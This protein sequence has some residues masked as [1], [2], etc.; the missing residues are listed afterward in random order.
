METSADITIPFPPLTQQT[1]ALKLVREMV[2]LYNTGKK[3]TR[4]LNIGKI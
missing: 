1:D 4:L 2:F 3:D